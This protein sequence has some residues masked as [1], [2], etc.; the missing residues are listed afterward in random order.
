MGGNT[1]SK[2]DIPERKV[3]EMFVTWLNG[4]EFRNDKDMMIALHEIKDECGI[5]LTAMEE[6]EAAA[7]DKAEAEGS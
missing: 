3:S 5:R 2:T 7:I 6:E 4:I 1:Y